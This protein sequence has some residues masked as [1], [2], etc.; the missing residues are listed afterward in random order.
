MLQCDVNLVDL[1]STALLDFHTLAR[2]ANLC[3]LT[4]VCEGR[5][6]QGHV[7]GGQWR[8]LGT[9]QVP[10]HQLATFDALLKPTFI[11]NQRQ[12]FVSKYGQ[13][14]VPYFPLLQSW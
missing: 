1:V 12:H 8:A 7:P 3:G 10:F 13:Y 14:R 2:Q 11:N 5:G 6:R 9:S 4:A